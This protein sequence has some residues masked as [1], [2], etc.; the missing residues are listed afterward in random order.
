MTRNPSTFSNLN[1]Y[2]RPQPEPDVL[3]AFP[4]GADRRVAPRYTI[5]RSV[6]I[7]SPRLP[8]VEGSL[9]NLSVTG[10]A[11][12]VIR[13]R[14]SDYRS[15]PLTRRNGEEVSV[16]RVLISPIPCWIVAVEKNTLRLRFQLD[17][18]MRQQLEQAILSLA[19]GPSASLHPPA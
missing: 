2:D 11:V 6:L 5:Q 19:G 9:V 4:A 13:P 10:C 16:F 15:W 12:Q 18:V 7:S 8:S 3:S 1:T 14:C 17:A